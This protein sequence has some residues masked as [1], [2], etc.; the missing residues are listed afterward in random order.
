[1]KT[2]QFA[3]STFIVM[4]VS[5][6]LSAQV[7]DVRS[8]QTNVLLDTAALSSAAG[9]DL[10]SVSGNVVVPGDLGAGSVAFLI[11][12]RDAV[13]PDLPTTFSYDPND[14]LGTFSGTI[15][16]TG[17]VFFNSDAVEVG[18]FTIGFDGGRASGSVSGFFVESTVGI[19]AILFDVENPSTL[20]PTSGSLT[21]AANL[22][23]SPE[24]G[25]F[26]LDQG[27]ATSNLTGVDVGD[28]L[29][30]AVVPEPSAVGLLMMGVSAFVMRRSHR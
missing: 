2:I 12:P 1:M 24:F 19:P 4:L 11:N 18:N 17:S 28:A 22:L 13:N 21:I 5:D 9:L 6:Q 20:N 8:G 23:V 26:L 15:E 25:Q 29:V 27:L 7:V 14:F 30:S 10:S 16:H 3:V